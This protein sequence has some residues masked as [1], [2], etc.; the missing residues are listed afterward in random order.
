MHLKGDNYKK[1]K[2]SPK[3]VIVQQL[4]I[5]ILSVSLFG[6]FLSQIYAYY[7]EVPKITDF[8]FTHTALF[9]AKKLYLLM[10]FS[11]KK[12]S[13]TMSSVPVFSYVFKFYI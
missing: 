7:S 8:A 4:G 3:N 1:L 9:W 11:L 10:K 5:S 13:I 12:I 2:I 6:C